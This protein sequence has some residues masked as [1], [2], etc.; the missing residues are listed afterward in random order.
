MIDDYPARLLW[1]KNAKEEMVTEA[2]IASRGVGETSV[3]TIK[4]EIA[5]GGVL[6]AWT[7]CE[8]SE[9]LRSAGPTRTSCRTIRI[10]IRACAPRLTVTRREQEIGSP[11][12][13]KPPQ[14][15]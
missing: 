11:V 15:R 8:G 2:Q 9:A 10:E 4:A 7:V 5:L 3:H 12:E 14:K 1:I 13:R 6:L